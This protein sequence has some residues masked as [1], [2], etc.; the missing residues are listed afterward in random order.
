MTFFDELKHERDHLTDHNSRF[1]CN[2]ASGLSQQ[3]GFMASVLQARGLT[4]EDGELPEEFIGQALKTLTMHEVGHTLGFRH[5]FK[6]STIFSLDELNNKR[7]EALIG[8]VMEYDAVNIA[9]EGKEQG[10]YYT[11]TIGPWDY[12][13]IEYA[14]KPIDASKPEGELEALGKIASRVATSDLTYGT[15][16]DASWY[17]FRDLDPL[18]N[19]WDLGDDPLAFAKTTARDR[20]RALGQDLKQS[21]KRG[22]GLSTCQ[23]C[24]WE[25]TF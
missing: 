12:W 15:D 3:M 20:R 8:S 24:I 11:K 4:D 23:A 1:H 22:N 25:P 17:R 7:D 10:D 19:R 9:A 16:E 6:A 14:Y 5:N 2:I 13:V 21:H 18:V